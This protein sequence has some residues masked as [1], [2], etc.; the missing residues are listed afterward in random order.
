PWYLGVVVAGLSLSA[1]ISSLLGG[2]LAH[3]FDGRVVFVVGAVAVGLSVAACSLVSPQS[4]RFLPCYWLLGVGMG[5]LYPPLIGWL[6][7]GE[8][9]HANR[10]GVSRTLILFCVSW[11]LGMLCGQLT[12][13]S[14]FARGGRWTYAAACS[15]A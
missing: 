6:N 7:Q 8:D 5:F 1:G 15:A 10:R 2:W 3:R 4:P 13:G 9:A 14:L 12:A 11:N